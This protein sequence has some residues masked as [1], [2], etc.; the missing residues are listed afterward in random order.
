[1]SDKDRKPRWQPGAVRP[2]AAG[3]DRGDK[4][5]RGMRKGGMF[6]S[7]HTKPL[8]DP[9]DRPR[10]LVRPRDVERI[11]QEEWTQADFSRKRLH[12]AVDRFST[13]STDI[14]AL[15]NASGRS[16]LAESLGRTR[17]DVAEIAA[18][19]SAT[20]L[21]EMEAMAASLPDP[22][23][24]KVRQQMRDLRQR[25][26][27]AERMAR[28][29]EAGNQHADTVFEG[30][31]TFGTY[32]DLVQHLHDPSNTQWKLVHKNAAGRMPAL[33]RALDSRTIACEDGSFV[34]V[35]AMTEEMV[36]EGQI[37]RRF[38]QQEAQVS[39]PVNLRRG[40]RLTDNFDGI[41]VV[42]QVEE[43]HK[44][45]FAGPSSDGPKWEATAQTNAAVF[46]DEQ[47][48][49]GVMTSQLTFGDSDVFRAAGFNAD[50]AIVVVEDEG[51]QRLQF[52]LARDKAHLDTT[53]AFARYNVMPNFEGI[54]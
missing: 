46:S 36:H 5:V 23:A 38:W 42:S 24:F 26:G 51:A 35:V 41:V 8:Q 3:G 2:S 32:K 15:T 16:V 52:N 43:D 20:T 31:P 1:M 29:I 4:G 50:Q 37:W 30:A 44:N 27:S 17:V 48:R 21:R 25:F 34:T 10:Q 6:L 47:C 53:R 13:V 9:G 40:V 12:Q 33:T 18:A 14:A 11:P 22:F 45:V 49:T 28:Y 54:H 39:M 19:D 7:D